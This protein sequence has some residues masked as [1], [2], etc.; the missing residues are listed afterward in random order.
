MKKFTEIIV[1]L[2]SVLFIVY[3]V[4]NAEPHNIKALDSNLEVPEPIDTLQVIKP[5]EYRAV[6]FGEPY[7]IDPTNVGGNHKNGEIY[8]IAREEGVEGWHWDTLKLSNDYVDELYFAG[9]L[10]NSK[11][12]FRVDED[13]MENIII[14]EYLEEKKS[15]LEA[16]IKKLGETEELNLD[17]KNIE[18]RIRN[19]A[20]HISN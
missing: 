17:L 2:A 16:A 20:L 5:R 10:G 18:K 7:I 9:L 12:Y 15:E 11:C 8:Y 19:H 13:S 4:Y 6:P 14:E 1:M 3:L